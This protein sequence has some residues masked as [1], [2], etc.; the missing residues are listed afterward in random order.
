M[1]TFATVVAASVTAAAAAAAAAPA[2]AAATAGVV[3]S[4]VGAAAA[5]A[6]SAAAGLAA[7][8]LKQLNRRAKLLTPHSAQFQSPG[9]S[10]LSPPSRA[11]RPMVMASGRSA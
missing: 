8:H 6:A 3:P 9:R 10:S 11:G 7:S 1:S 5:T 2:T 4:A